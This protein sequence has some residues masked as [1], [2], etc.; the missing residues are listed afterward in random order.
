MALIPGWG[1]FA[2]FF[3]AA[4]G[5]ML[6]LDPA[7]ILS[8]SN[9]FGGVVGLTVAVLSMLLT[10]AIGVLL[11]IFFADN[12]IK[13]NR[14]GLRI[15][16]AVHLM[17]MFPSETRWVDISSVQISEDEKILQFKSGKRNLRVKLGG[18]KRDDLERLALSIDL[19]ARPESKTASFQS[20]LDSVQNRQVANLTSFTRMWEEELQQRFS[21]TSF[22]PLEPNAVLKGGQIRVLRQL[23]FGGLSAIYLCQALK[24]ELFV[25]KELV[26]PSDANDEVKD[27]ALEL[28]RREAEILVKLDHPGIVKVFDHFVE[29]SRHYLLLE[30]LP[31]TNLRQLVMEGGPVREAEVL[32]W[33]LQICELLCYFEQ[34]TPPLVHRDLTPDNLVMNS[35]R[36]LVLIDF[37]AANDFVGK[38]TG[39]LVGKQSYMAPEQFRGK[40]SPSSDI[41]SLGGTM[42]FLL[43]G[44]DPEPLTSSAPRQLKPTLLECTDVIVQR[45]TSMNESDRYSSAVELRQ[46]VE[47]ALEIFA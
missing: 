24:K 7:V 9:N 38:S 25:L 22:V 44:A 27:K 4:V 28:F 1:I 29:N 37:G 46:A 21:A 47:K 42:H 30:Y 33:A 26:I 13:L 14:D 2:P 11:T 40:A 19:W 10:T 32:R 17:T 36:K 31:G 6:L 43:T 41:Y 12:R 8:G 34:R 16:A 39:T 45:C 35:D 20:F 18:F 23:S 15:P 3:V 5:L